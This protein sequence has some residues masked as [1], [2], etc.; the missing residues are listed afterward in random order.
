MTN[1]KE[2][3]RLH[4]LGINNTPHCG[5]LQLCAQHSHSSPF[6]GPQNRSFPGI[7]SRTAAQK[8]LPGSCIRPTAPGPAVQDARL[9]VGTP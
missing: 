4:S 9:R 5:K 3:L 1:Y 2:I 7:R 6:S 8:K